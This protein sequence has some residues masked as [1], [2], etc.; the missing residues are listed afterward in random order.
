MR[1]MTMDGV[2]IIGIIRSIDITTINQTF[3]II[4]NRLLS[5]IRNLHHLFAIISSHLLCIIRNPP[6][7]VIINSN[8]LFV[9]TH[10]SI[11]VMNSACR[12]N[13]E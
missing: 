10:H 5:I 7:F 2:I 13:D 3:V 1:M 6:L 4:N 9:L 12:G 8:L 11:R